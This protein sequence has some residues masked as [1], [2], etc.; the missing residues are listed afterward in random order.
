MITLFQHQEEGYKRLLRYKRYCLFFEVGT[1]KTYTA[2]AAL[3]KLPTDYKVL[4]VAPTRA[5]DGVWKVQN[6]FDVSGY[7]ITYMSYEKIAR[8]KTFT[9]NKYDVIILDE[10]HKIKGKTSK[11]SKKISAVAKWAEYVWGLT[12]TPVANSYADVYL[13]FKHMGINEFE[14]SYDEFISYYYVTRPLK[15]TSNY[16]IQLPVQPKY[17]LVDSLI[18]RIGN[19]SMT[20]RMQDCHEL[21]DIMYNT[22]YI[23]GMDTKKYKEIFNGII[24]TDEYEETVNKLAAI[25][26]ARQAAN[27]YFYDLYTSEPVVFEYNKKLDVFKSKVEDYLEETEK[28][29]VVY[30]FKQDL[31]DIQSLDFKY[32]FDPVEFKNN[33]DVNILLLQYGQCEALNLQFC[34][35][36]IF[37]TYDYSYLK[38]EQ[39]V[40]RIKRIGQ[41]NKMVIDILIN[42]NTIENKVWNAIKYKQTTDEFLKGV[43]SE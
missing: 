22:T 8:D 10:V 23:Y 16:S 6:G 11:S 29:I 36:I 34:N 37:Y 18:D 43:L 24:K 26:K 17:S 2:L 27:G 21:P 39:M 25:T 12:G 19:H 1:G 35:H 7:D 38:F 5:I 40:G 13:I 42:Y 41:N 20:V 32:T 9:K 3:T 31:K 15:V 33:N 28:L 4:I 30:F 14:M